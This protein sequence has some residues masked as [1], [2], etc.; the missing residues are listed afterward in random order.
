MP[1]LDPLTGIPLKDSVKPLV[2]AFQ[3]SGDRWAAIMLD[4]DHFKLVND[5]HGHFAG[6]EA[7]SGIAAAISQIIEQGDHLSRFGG[8]EFLLV[9]RGDRASEAEAV[10][11]RIVSKVA[12]LKTRKNLRIT[13]SAGV[14][15]GTGR[16]G[17]LEE[18]IEL[19][20]RALYEA[21]DSGRGKVAVS[22][23]EGSRPAGEAPSFTHLIGRRTELK[24][25]RQLAEETLGGGGRAVLLT[26]E[27]GVGKS[28]LA[29]EFRRV[30]EMH[31]HRILQ[32]RCTEFFESEPYRI[33]VQPLGDLLESLG[34][35]AVERIAESAGS[36]HPATMELL[37]GFGGCARD[38]VQ[39]FREERLRFRIL[40]DVS[41][42]LNAAS[43]ETPLLLMVED[44]QWL[45][46]PDLELLS[47]AVRSSA[48]FPIVSLF[49]TRTVP[50]APDP[51]LERL[52]S[53]R[54]SIPL[55][56][57]R[58]RNLDADE[59]RAFVMFSLHDPGVPSE[60]LEMM[61]RQSGGNPLFLRELLV[62]F[63]EDGTLR[64]RLG[65]R[66]YRIPARMQIPSTLAAIMDRKLGRLSESD[67][68]V[69]KIASLTSGLFPAALLREIGGADPLALAATLDRAIT[70][71]VLS[72]VRHQGEEDLFTFTHDAMRNFL[73]ETIS[74][75]LRRALHAGIS[76]FFERLCE[77]GRDDFLAA[78]AYHALLGGVDERAA[79]LTWA[80][81]MKALARRANLDAIR[82]LESFLST[83]GAKDPARMYLAERNLGE[84]KSITGDVM[85]ASAHLEK[86]LGLAPAGE[87]AEVMVLQ[88]ENFYRASM[89]TEARG[90]FSAALEATG[91][92]SLRTEILVYLAFLDYIAG[93][94]PSGFAKLDQAGEVLALVPGDDPRGH[95]AKARYFTRRGDF[96]SAT[97]PGGE[98]LPWYEKAL[99]LYRMH[100]DRIGEALVKNNMS[101]YYIRTSEYGRALEMLG[102]VLRINE[103]YDD[104]LGT[105]IACFN[106]ADISSRVN[107]LADAEHYFARYLQVSRRIHNDL[108][109]GYGTLGLGLL[110]LRCGRT[111]EAVV[112]LRRAVEVFDRLGS[113][114]L[115]LE[116]SL[117]LCEALLK[118]GSVAEAGEILDGLAEPGDESLAGL[119]RYLRGLFL[120]NRP[121]PDL[122]G[123]VELIGASLSGRSTL[124]EIESAERSL[125]LAGAL[126]AAGD[127]DAAARVLADA[128]RDLE[129][130]IAALPD[131]DVRNSLSCAGPVARILAGG[132]T[133]ESP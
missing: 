126:G 5:I 35:D 118:D 39:Y 86:A 131:E 103:Q 37:P 128:G 23:S 98:A 20:D 25:L 65:E 24:K 18:I 76:S 116:A 68:S 114:A 4:I 89:Y 33:L 15:T 94:F 91:D 72:E 17:S 56:D 129:A 28:R 109:E 79:D 16:E 44:A 32:A 88:G 30:W 115:R 22:S 67:L 1:D 61:H 69:L 95:N 107:R 21:K 6:D 81:A 26:G 78:A 29:E 50:G 45:S 36:L 73:S 127:A 93:D 27:E 62:S 133:G 14:C 8:D 96:L 106:I 53:L 40:E 52:R 97:T 11:E 2:R 99:D 58:L 123:A 42:V 64:T 83:S 59:S 63:H 120:K 46:H 60:F 3:S 105:A 101:D 19:A 12:S 43:A 57:L 121:D 9:L 117:R 122:E 102:E 111:S 92:P 119:W 85:A 13:I 77:A 48:M 87:G 41:K 31:G 70:A 75:P 84:L 112:E 66:T 38:D 55:L 90:S 82:W 130:R 34:R 80:A 132:C 71:G 125:E 108:G 113:T 110:R 51:V 49:A 124:S 47:F 100:E 7:L 104:A 74:G 54:S 10:A